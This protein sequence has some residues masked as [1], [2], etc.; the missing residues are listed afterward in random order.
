MGISEVDILSRHPVPRH[1]LTVAQYR[2][3][4]EIGILD[5]DERVELLEGQLVAMSPIGPRHAFVVGTLTILLMPP[6]GGP[7]RLLVQNPVTL[8]DGSEPQPDIALVSHP[9]P[10]SPNTHPG[11]RDIHL[12]VEVADSSLEFDL[13]AKANIYAR[14]AIRE[15]WVIDLTTDTVHVHRAPSG[16]TYRATAEV[17][18]PAMLDIE[19]LPGA[20]VAAAAIFA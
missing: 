20:T 16:G 2:R 19:A 12:L 1:R 17:R 18:A 5:E 6:R 3:M 14:A 13:R 7:V 10:G 8:D 9:W 11:P 4:G 15:Y